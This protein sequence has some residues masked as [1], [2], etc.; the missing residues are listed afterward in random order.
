[1]RAQI[2][3]LVTAVTELAQLVDVPTSAIDSVLALIKL[4]TRMAGTG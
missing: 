4:R 2:D 3:A 1:M